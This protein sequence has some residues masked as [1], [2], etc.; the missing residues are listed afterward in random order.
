MDDAPHPSVAD[1]ETLARIAGTRRVRAL[2]A[3]L[4]RNRIRYF[5]S[6][7]NRPSTTIAALDRAL[8]R[9]TDEENEPNYDPPPWDKTRKA[10]SG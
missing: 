1:F 9:G 10:R 8:R 2:K 4:A 3:W 5:N 7:K 6:V